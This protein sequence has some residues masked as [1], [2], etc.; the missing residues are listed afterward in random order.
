[1]ADGKIYC[2]AGKEK[3]KLDRDLNPTQL[4]PLSGTILKF[5]GQ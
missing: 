5:W 1:M 2:G 3:V 4:T